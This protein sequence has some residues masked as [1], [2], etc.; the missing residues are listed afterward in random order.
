LTRRRLTA[1]V[2][3][4]GLAVALLFPATPAGAG[5]PTAQKSGEELLTYLTT[6][7]LKVKSSLK[8]LVQCGAPAP[9][10]CFMEARS[11]IV[12]KG[13]NLKVSSSGVFPAGSVVEVFIDIN[14]PVRSAIKANLKKSKLRTTVSATNDLTGEVDEDSVTFKFKKK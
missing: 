2:S 4:A 3:T 10:N 13:P 6:G 9:A 12:L 5:G 8:Y 7:K 14:K 1:I 11:V